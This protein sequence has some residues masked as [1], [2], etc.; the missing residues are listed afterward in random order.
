MPPL[1]PPGLADHVVPVTR[2]SFQRFAD[3]GFGVGDRPQFL[4]GVAAPDPPALPEL[5]A[6]KRHENRLPVC[7]AAGGGMED[8]A[9]EG[10]TV[11]QARARPQRSSGRRASPSPRCPRVR[12]SRRSRDAAAAVPPRSA[13]IP[14]G[15]VLGVDLEG[16]PDLEWQR[17]S[18][19]KWC[20]PLAVWKRRVTPRRIGWRSASLPFSAAGRT[21][22]SVQFSERRRFVSSEWRSRRHQNLLLQPISF[23][24]GYDGDVVVII[25]FAGDEHESV[26]CQQHSLL[27]TRHNRLP[28]RPRVVALEAYIYY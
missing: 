1:L 16:G 11:C 9:K 18:G 6:T 28:S 21:A 24:Q 13:E 10:D 27:S 22:S 5:D 14:V 23:C 7:K 3:R 26:S 17:F 2:S 8:D 15:A 12:P 4:S 20:C 19:E 25:L